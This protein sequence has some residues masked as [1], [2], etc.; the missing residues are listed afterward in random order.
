MAD[1]EFLCKVMP[2]QAKRRIDCG[3][4]PEEIDETSYVL[5]SA[6]N[7]RFVTRL[8]LKT[9]FIPIVSDEE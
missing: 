3:K 1:I 6:K 4:V 7:G 9:E 5:L 2:R 8:I